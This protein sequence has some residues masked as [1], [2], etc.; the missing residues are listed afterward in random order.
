MR[1][2]RVEEEP[3]QRSAAAASEFPVLGLCQKLS[4]DCTSRRVHVR[5]SSK[6]SGA[7]PAFRIFSSWRQKCNVCD[8]SCQRTARV[9]EARRSPPM[10]QR[11]EGRALVS[12]LYRLHCIRK[13]CVK[14]P[15]GHI[16]D[17]VSRTY[18]WSVPLQQ[19][20]ECSINDA[21]KRYRLRFFVPE[22]ETEVRLVV[23][24]YS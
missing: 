8:L 9:V 24:S 13:H 7:C 19:P 10:P 18:L 12:M 4:R 22:R 11:M 17:T 23:Q 2:A 16:K 1:H 21:Q 6:C 3:S 14:S 15:V 5:K 20:R